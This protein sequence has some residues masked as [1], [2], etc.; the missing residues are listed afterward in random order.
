MLHFGTIL[1]IVGLVGSALAEK[2][3]FLS[4][5][6]NFQSFHPH[7]YLTHLRLASHSPSVPAQ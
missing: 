4:A 6:P 5:F 2:R 3:E 1:V 7:H